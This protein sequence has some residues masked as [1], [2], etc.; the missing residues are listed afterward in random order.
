MLTTLLT[1][2]VGFVVRPFGALVFGR[3]GDLVGRKH[4]FLI[5]I[6]VREPR[7]RGRKRRG[8]HQLEIVLPELVY[9]R[10]VAVA[11]ET[12]RHKASLAADLVIKALLG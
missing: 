5:A 9:Q 1:F 7:K 4:A 12:G 11:R 8:D 6:T 10:L 3:S 2:G